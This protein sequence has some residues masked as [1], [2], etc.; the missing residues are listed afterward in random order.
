MAEVA[1]NKDELGND[2]ER[3]LYQHKLPEQELGF[4]ELLKDHTRGEKFPYVMISTDDGPTD[5]SRISFLQRFQAL[6]VSSNVSI[7]KRLNMNLVKEVEEISFSNCFGKKIKME[8]VLLKKAVFVLTPLSSMFDRYTDV[9]ACI[10]D[11]RFR[12]SVI[13]QELLLSSNKDYTGELSLD[14]SI[15]KTSLDKV[16]FCVNLETPIM[17]TGEQWASIQIEL[18]VEESDYPQ[19]PN[20]KRVLATSS[21]PR[22]GLLKYNYNPMKMDL[23]IHNNHRDQLLEMYADGDLVRPS[24]PETVKT[25]K[26]EYA[27]S[28]APTVKKTGILKVPTN[29]WE[30]VQNRAPDKIPMD[31]KSISLIDPN[32]IKPSPPSSVTSAAHKEEELSEQARDDD[33]LEDLKKLRIMQEQEKAFGKEVHPKKVGFN[34]SDV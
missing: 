3:R 10:V 20:F 15:P 8:F 24:D 30:A 4:G 6:I 23:S 21:M 34:V 5:E 27:K 17:N 1:Q 25:G 13:R 28:S 31:Q 18:D 29:D 2:A 32:E 16:F 7:P 22:S 11:K 26:L 12:G 19:R 9:L 33:V 14:Y